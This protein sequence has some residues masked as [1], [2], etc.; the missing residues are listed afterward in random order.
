MTELEKAC[1]ELVKF[2]YSLDD[3]REAFNKENGE[4]YFCRELHSIVPSSF[5]YKVFP[6]NMSSQMKEIVEWVD[7]FLVV[8]GTYQTY[9]DDSSYVCDKIIAEH[10]PAYYYKMG[11]LPLYLAVEGKNRV[12]LFQKHKRPIKAEIS[13]LNMPNPKNLTLHETIFG[14]TILLSCDD[15][16]YTSRKD[17][18]FILPFPEIAVPIYTA[19][20]VKFGKRKWLPLTTKNQHQIEENLVFW[21]M[22]R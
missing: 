8:G 20:G 18:I 7:P 5:M 11:N 17:S 21:S 2:K 13:Q 12:K 22:G 1:R 10:S 15:S 14:K 4:E 6:F 19:Y 3:K 16:H 9:E